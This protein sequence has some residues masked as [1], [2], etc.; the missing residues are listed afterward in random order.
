M[1]EKNHET[2][3]SLHSMIRAVIASGCIQNQVEL[4]RREGF[5]FS[6]IR[7]GHQREADY[8]VDHMVLLKDRPP[9]KS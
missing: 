8:E 2:P 1:N 4:E 9:L 5:E 7:I 3:Y 6:C